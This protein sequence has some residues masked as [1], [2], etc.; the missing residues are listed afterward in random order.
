[1]LRFVSQLTKAQFSCLLAACV[2]FVVVCIYPPWTSK[3]STAHVQTERSLGYDWLF[4]P[5]TALQ[6]GE[7]VCLDV[8]RLLVQWLI[9]ILITAILLATLE[10]SKKESDVAAMPRNKLSP[11]MFIPTISIIFIWGMAVYSDQTNR[12]KV[13]IE[14]QAARARNSF[15]GLQPIRGGGLQYTRSGGGLQYAGRGQP[16]PLSGGGGGLDNVSDDELMRMWELK[17]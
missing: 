9:V 6:S 16:L 13:E 5:P 11:W 7:S 10:R 14:K 2:A 1:M 3:I 17:K 12:H 4:Q 8:T 15:I